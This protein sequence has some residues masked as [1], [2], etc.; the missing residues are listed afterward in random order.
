V[1]EPLIAFP[2]VERLVVDSIKDRP[3]LAGVLVDN[4]PPPDFDG[5]RRA[6]LISRVGGAWID[7][8]HLD[9]PLI[10]FEAY[11]PDKSTAHG[12]ALA[13]R[14]VTIGL[15][16]VDYGG[17]VVVDVIEEDGPRWLPDYHH[18]GS[19]RYLSTVRLVIRPS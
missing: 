4:R 14:A 19:N 18:P 10:D 1:T 7:D 16:G 8:Q 3:Q 9:H 17:A 12:V 2:D 11:G 6:V 13:A 15:R 5:T